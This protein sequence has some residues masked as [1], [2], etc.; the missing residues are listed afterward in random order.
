M[1]RD[2]ESIQEARDLASAAFTA[3][4]EFEHFTEEQVDRILA[5]ISKA[6]IAHASA[7]AK[8]AVEETGYGTVEHKTL[9]NL[10]CAR[11]VYNAIRPMKTIGSKSVCHM[12]PPAAGAAG[13]AWAGAINRSSRSIL[14]G[15][16]M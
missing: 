2:L 3:F 5:E 12:L 15:P 16:A 9:K 4:Q 11:D 8:L 14:L 1:N 6:G 13:W 10:F 7:L